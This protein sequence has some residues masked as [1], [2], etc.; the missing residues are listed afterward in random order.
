VVLVVR[1][2]RKTSVLGVVP[3]VPLP[4]P[5]LTL[6]ALVLSLVMP[7]L[8]LGMM[9]QT[10]MLFATMFLVMRAPTVFTGALIFVLRLEPFVLFAPPLLVL[11]L[12]RR[13]IKHLP[14]ALLFVARLH[15]LC[16][17]AAV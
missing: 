12:R 15:G 10:A 6:P 1:V 7:C 5:S 14:S 13:R 3:V 11:A 17:H 16:F 9:G 8:V 4:F 2:M